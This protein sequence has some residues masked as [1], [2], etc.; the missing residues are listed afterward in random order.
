MALYDGIDTV[1]YASNGSYTETYTTAMN[2]GDNL[3]D[4]FCSFGLL[5]DVPIPANKILRKI[6]RKIFSI[7]ILAKALE[8]WI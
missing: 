3:A 4:L 1:A 6:F 8:I 7:P 5:E 2:Q